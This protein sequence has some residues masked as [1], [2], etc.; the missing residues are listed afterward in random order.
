MYD[1][2]V[3]LDDAKY[4]D[5]TRRE[6]FVRNVSR[7]FAAFSELLHVITTTG[8]MLASPITANSGRY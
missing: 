8:G 7:E 4:D 1:R 5:Y 2:S 3:M 6:V